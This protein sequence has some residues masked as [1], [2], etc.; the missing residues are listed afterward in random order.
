MS[1]GRSI[2]T[3]ALLYL[4]INIPVFVKCLEHL[5]ESIFIVLSEYSFSISYKAFQRCSNYV[6]QVNTNLQCKALFNTFL[7]KELAFYQFG[8]HIL[9][10]VC[11]ALKQ[12]AVPVRMSKKLYPGSYYSEYYH[13]RV[14]A[15]YVVYDSCNV[16][17]HLYLL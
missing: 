11:S 14:M 4:S 5:E 9:S 2:P 12:L 13:S 3:G 1:N 7:S 6:K 17:Y 16:P 10:H 15:M 8:V